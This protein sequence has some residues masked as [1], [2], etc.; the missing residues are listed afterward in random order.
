MKCPLKSKFPK[1][2]EHHLTSV[3]SGSILAVPKIRIWLYRSIDRYGPN[4]GDQ[5]TFYGGH[6]IT[7]L[8]WLVCFSKGL[9]T[10]DI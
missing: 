6:K 4:P 2:Y 8:I 7:V 5:A 10:L 1:Y 9:F 3:I